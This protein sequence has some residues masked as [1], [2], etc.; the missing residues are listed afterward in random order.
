MLALDS[1]VPEVSGQ[2]QG[3]L[4]LRGTPAQPRLSANIEGSDLAYQ[5]QTLAALKL[6]ADLEA[7]ERGHFDLEGSDLVLAGQSFKTL[8]VTGKGERSNHVLG[9]KLAGEPAQVELELGGGLD[10]QATHWQGELRTLNLEPAGHT[11]WHLRE[12]ANVAID[13]D[14]GSLALSSTCLEAL[15]ARACAQVDAKG[16]AMQGQF[17]LQDLDLSVFD[18]WVV[19]ALGQP[20]TIQGLLAANGHF[21]TSQSGE[22]QATLE[23]A[24]PQLT[25]Q[26][27]LAAEA[28]TFT[29]SDLQVTARVDAERATLEL[30]AGTLGEGHVQVQ[31]STLAP[32]ADDGEISGN[33]D[34]QLPDLGVLGLLSDQVVAPEGVLEGRLALAGTRQEPHLDGQLELSGFTAQLPALGITP[35]AGQIRLQGTDAGRLKLDGSMRLGEGTATVQ[36]QFDL[37]A[38]D[39]PTGSL[40]IQGE[41]LTVASIPE[42]KVRASPDLTLE[43][44]GS[45]L[46]LR[47]KVTVP[48]A[49]I[50][51][52]RLES[53]ATPSSDVVIVD[54]PETSS[55]PALDADITVLLG[56]SVRM[57]GFGLRGTLAGQ[58]R[59]RDL[60]DQP[61]TARGA[62]DVGGRYKAYGQDLTITRGQ[63]AWASTPIDTPALDIRAQRKIDAITVGV[64]VRG[65]AVTPELSLWSDPAMEQAE[66]LSYLI[67]GRPLRSASQAEGSELSQAAAA[68][69]GNYLAKGIGERLGLDEIEVA[70]NRA[71]GGAALTVGMYLSPRLHVSYGVA[72]FGDGQVMSF[73]YLLSRL[74]NI[75]LDSGTEDRVTLNYRLER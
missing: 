74:W 18:T 49:R 15:P 56:Q 53:V 21:E 51:L 45:V 54:A 20:A 52:E 39:G 42:A 23:A 36:G 71:L 5:D 30:T 17:E 32:F 59:V 65:T 37:T 29:L 4:A 16:Q 6:Q 72:L 2:L 67:L 75:Q 1:F 40:T 46:K 27:E 73:K 10:D 14:A 12:A 25:L 48:W 9:L 7:Y 47:G 8:V 69:G 26:P 57:S 55:G 13:L 66:Q 63:V 31:A 64:Q 22:L 11:P 34:L 24:I 50:D 28:H 60:P 70:D 19:S 61:T 3:D 35:E 58:L 41:D 43:L 68:L 33:V 62:I 44:G 38:A